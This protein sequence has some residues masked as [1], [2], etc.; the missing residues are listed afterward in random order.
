MA[1]WG[2]PRCCGDGHSD[3]AVPDRFTVY[4][5]R[6]CEALGRFHNLSYTTG[7]RLWE[8]YEEFRQAVIDSTPPELTLR[9]KGRHLWGKSFARQLERD[10]ARKFAGASQGAG[11]DEA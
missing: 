10:I 1:S 9:E 3:R 8:R 7:D 6:V 4:D 11:T 5:V 2:L